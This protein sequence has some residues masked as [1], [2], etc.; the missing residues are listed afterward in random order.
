M[1]YILKEGFSGFRRAKLSTIISIVTVAISL[2]LLG[3]FTIIFLNLHQFAESVRK[4]IQLEVFIHD[5][6]AVSQHA[7]LQSRIAAIP[8][9]GGVKYISKD[10]AARIFQRDFGEDIHSVLDFNPLPASYQISLEPEYIHPDSVATLAA[11][12]QE[13]E[14]TD[15]VVYG[16]SLLEFLTSRI[17]TFIAVSAGVGILLGISAIFL[18]SN[19]IRLTIYAKRK[20]IQTMRL[21]GATRGFIRKPF[22]LEGFVQGLLGGVLAFGCIYGALFLMQRRLPETLN[23]VVDPDLQFYAAILLVGSCLGLLGSA[24]SIR[25]FLK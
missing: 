8:G 19:T 24:V 9:V 14:G 3:T 6:F 21:V 7:A 12:I 20:L 25:R 1:S 4:E 23:S 10:E 22:L 18:V 11:A 13:L 5:A 16:K 17:Q 2:I 15:R